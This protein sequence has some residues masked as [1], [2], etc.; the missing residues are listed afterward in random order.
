MKRTETKNERFIRVATKR[1][2][3]IVD[4]MDTLRPLSNRQVYEYT[5]EQIDKV[6]NHLEKELRT[7]R[8]GF[9]SGD[10]S[11]KL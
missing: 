6:F 4:A 3:K 8:A 1:A 7:I 2:N 5:D 10:W 11:F 9:N